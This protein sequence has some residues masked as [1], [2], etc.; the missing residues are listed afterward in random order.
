MSRHPSNHH[1]SAAPASGPRAT[2]LVVLLVAGSGGVLSGALVTH[3]SGWRP[4]AGP[5]R[6]NDSVL[7]VA[8][9]LPA[10]PAGPQRAVEGTPMALEDPAAP[11]ARR[12]G[13]TGPRRA[14]D[15]GGSGVP[16]DEPRPGGPELHEV[17][18]HHP[19]G[20]LRARGLERDGR[21][22]GTWVEY[23]PGGTP[24][25]EGEYEGDLRRGTWRFWDEDGSPSSSGGYARSRRE[26]RWVSW[27]PGGERRSEG[28]YEDGRRVGLWREWY[29][30]GQ[31]KEA[32]HY[33][34]GR[35][36][37]P[38]QFFHFDGTRDQRTGFY[39]EGARVRE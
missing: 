17:L 3:S 27:H 15:D 12:R 39:R 9:A 5:G 35:R 2:V 20:G 25:S 26:G 4:D 21:R 36:E 19:G 11:P 29:S 38:W 31:V 33:V 28:R 1:R 22:E 37:G 34:D 18:L 16:P 24:A 23:W 8:G 14:P 13:P 32:G 7:L 10:G 30:N 6:T